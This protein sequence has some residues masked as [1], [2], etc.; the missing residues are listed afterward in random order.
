MQ[1]ILSCFCILVLMLT[2]VGCNSSGQKELTNHAKY[3]SFELILQDAIIEEINDGTK[4]VKIKA[5]YTNSSE[6]PQ[7]AY[8]SFV[9][10]AFQND[11]E[12]K[13]LS[14]I[15]GNQSSLIQETKNKA[16]VSVSYVFE[17]NDESPVEVLIDE[18][19]VDQTTIGQKTYFKN[20]NNDD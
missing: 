5:E 1:K 12:L 19:T 13:D 15:N 18:P 14:D 9:V 7:Y 8:S 17:L 16:K 10:K 11:K 6:E 2:L 20:E 4:I 3:D